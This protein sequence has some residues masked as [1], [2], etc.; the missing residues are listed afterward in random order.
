MRFDVIVLGLGAMGS[1]TLD[2]LA[3]RGVNALGIE[4]FGIPHDLGSSGGD[5]RLIRK[6][7]FEHPDYVPLLE[8]AYT[9]WAELESR[10]GERVLFR[11]G[12]VYVGAEHGTTMQGTR[13]SADKYA[14]RCDWLSAQE[15]T[16]RW[17][18]MTVPSGA[19]AL[20]EPDGGFVLAGKAIR[21]FCESALRHGATIH[22][23][24]PALTW[25]ETNEGVEVRTA[26]ETYRA[27]R[28]VVTVGSWTASLLSG[29][30]TPLAVTRQ[31]AF[32]TWPPAADGFELG[33]FGCW[34]AELDGIPGMFY[35][36]P[37]LAASIGGQLGLKVA[38]HLAGPLAEAGALAPAT[39][40]EFAPV[41]KALAAVFR[42][43]LGPVIG[44]KACSYTSTLDQHFVVDRLPGS[45][46]AFVA[47]GFSGHG[48]KFASVIGEVLADMAVDGRTRL[49][50][51]FLG[52]ARLRSAAAT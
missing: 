3:R 9:N 29:L 23:A 15:V 39:A 11:T 19:R 30:P 10:S 38:H 28:L 2:Q 22:A 40:A 36:F 5:T 34:A 37:L 33:A 8:R 4:R 25:R 20:H 18:C 1:A 48:F 50:I 6:A 31:V 47:C 43:D 41:R 45:E 44:A 42:T 26:A 13:A 51:D 46:R 7:Y 21:L 12:I 27:A 49:P 16:S 14:L 52:L 24:E 32:W 35:G 17:P